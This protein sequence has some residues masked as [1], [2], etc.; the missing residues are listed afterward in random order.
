MSQSSNNIF[1]GIGNINTK[2]NN[3]S[4]APGV[5]EGEAV[6]LRFTKLLSMS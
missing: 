5:V 2:S 3:A 1:A 6:V 4:V